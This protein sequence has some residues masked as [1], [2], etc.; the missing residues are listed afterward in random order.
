MIAS[1]MNSPAPMSNTRSI[2]SPFGGR[3]GDSVVPLLA[4]AADGQRDGVTRAVAADRHDQLCAALDRLA[5]DGD[6]DV[7]R[8]EPSLV[9]GPVG[10]DGWRPG[11]RRGRGDARSLALDPAVQ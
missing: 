3:E 1:A 8:L 10:H 4:A 7:P 9:G 2:L 6:D 11:A 5:V